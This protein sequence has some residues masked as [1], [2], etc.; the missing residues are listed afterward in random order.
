M[1][2]GF[3]SRARDH[4]RVCPGASEGGRKARAHVETVLGRIEEAAANG[5]R[6]MALPQLTNWAYM[7]VDRAE[8]SMPRRGGRTRGFDLGCLRRPG[9]AGALSGSRR[10]EADLGRNGPVSG[11]PERSSRRG[12]AFLILGASAAGTPSTGFCGIAGR[13]SIARIAAPTS[14]VAGTDIQQPTREWIHAW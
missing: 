8:A 5:A 10:A 14:N 11:G 2:A 3:S 6:F 13:T 12:S 9:P 4:P 1:D 7:F